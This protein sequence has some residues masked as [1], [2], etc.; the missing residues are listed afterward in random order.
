MRVGIARLE[1]V[2]IDWVRFDS[3]DFPQDSTQ[4]CA[5]S[6]ADCWACA[7]RFESDAVGI[8]IARLG[9]T[10]KP[11]IYYTLRILFYISWIL[12]R[13]AHFESRV[14]CPT[15]PCNIPITP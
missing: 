2:V 13:I 3:S 5:P 8:E 11:I 12:G 6:Q 9:Y 10:Q 4:G 14:S 1:I 15:T 7:Y